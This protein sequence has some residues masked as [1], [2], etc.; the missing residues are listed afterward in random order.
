[1]LFLVEILQ[2]FLQILEMIGLLSNTTKFLNL[3]EPLFF[4]DFDIFDWCIF[5]EHFLFTFDL[6][7]KS[8]NGSPLGLPNFFDEFSESLLNNF[9]LL[10]P[11]LFEGILDVI[12]DN[13]L[14]EWILLLLNFVEYFQGLFCVCGQIDQKLVTTLHS[15]SLV[16]SEKGTVSTNQCAILATHKISRFGVQQT[17]IMIRFYDFI[18]AV[19]PRGV[20]FVRLLLLG[21]H[22]AQ[23]LLIYKESL[24]SVATVLDPPTINRALQ[25]FGQAL[26]TQT[27]LTVFESEWFVIL[28][29]TLLAFR[30]I[31]CVHN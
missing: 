13:L 18:F 29:E 12:L 8:N 26:L 27:M 2:G 10:S 16:F 30:A 7:V 5:G 4:F 11:L 20:Q 1:M 21:L 25:S 9:N 24:G 22:F 17:Y 3:S 31:Q 28:R 6:I 23:D 15:V 14:I 19:F